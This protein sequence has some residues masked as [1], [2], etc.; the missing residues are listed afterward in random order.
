M[1]PAALQAPLDYLFALSVSLLAVGTSFLVDPR[2]T[3]WIVFAVGLLM[4]LS[5]TVAGV[6]R[7]PVRG[8]KE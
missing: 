2:S 1:K 7:V 4:V 5:V 6:R 8:S 3:G